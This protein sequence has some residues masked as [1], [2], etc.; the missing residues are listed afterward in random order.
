MASSA[1]PAKAVTL[2]DIPGYGKLSKAPDASAPLLVVFG[3]KDVGVPSGAYMWN[4]MSDIKDRFHIFVAL[5]QS[6][7]RPPGL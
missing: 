4:Y 7:E 1:V 3:G 6:R 5:N 2:I